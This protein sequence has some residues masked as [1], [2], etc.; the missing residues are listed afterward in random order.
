MVL[1]SHLN[2]EVAC[3]IAH[4]P[5]PNWHVVAL[6]VALIDLAR[7]HYLVIRVLDEL[8]PVGHPA[9]EPGQRKQHSEVFCWYAYCLVDDS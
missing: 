9:R 1:I 4:V 5:L 6:G 7:P 2:V 3:K 8:V